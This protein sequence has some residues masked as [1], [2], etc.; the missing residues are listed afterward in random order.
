MKTFKE[1]TENLLEQIACCDL[2]SDKGIDKA[3]RLILMALKEQDRDTRH[4][5]AEAVI[6]QGD[7]AA[8]ELIDRC[9]NAC[10]NAFSS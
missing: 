3:E 5:C 10:M 1:K 4:A 6:R 2:H 8:I 7:A 9:H